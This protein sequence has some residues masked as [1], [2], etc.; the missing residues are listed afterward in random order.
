MR[1]REWPLTPP[2]YI[3]PSAKEKKYLLAGRVE[4]YA[5]TPAHS[6]ATVASVSDIHRRT[7]SKHRIPAGTA[8]RRDTVQGFAS[9]KHRGHPCL[10]YLQTGWSAKLPARCILP[11]LPKKQK[12]TRAAQQLYEDR[13]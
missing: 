1:S 5:T 7:V 9:K 13:N 6:D 3:M 11:R 4:P 8:L 2:P 12:S 10:L